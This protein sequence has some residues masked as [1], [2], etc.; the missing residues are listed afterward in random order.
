MSRERA[1]Y[2]ETV[3]DKYD[4]LPDGAFWTV[5]EEQG[6]YPEDVEMAMEVLIAV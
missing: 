5:L 1:S 4:A 3:V 2:I 6:I